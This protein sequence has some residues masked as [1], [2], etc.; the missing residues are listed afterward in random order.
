MRNRIFLALDLVLCAATVLLAFAARFEGVSWPPS[1]QSIAFAYLVVVV[2]L[3][4]ILLF[5]VGLYRR[6]WRYASIADLEIILIAAFLGALASFVVGFELPA[7]GLTA[8]RVPIGVMLLYSALTAAAISL[9]RLLLRVIARRA[10]SRR[11]R[12]PRGSLREPMDV[13][14][15]LIAGEFGYANP[16][17]DA[18]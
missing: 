3:K 9:P 15:V 11:T 18:V 8:G 13:R 7:A 4:I 12:G 2:P 1:I 10:R 5:S 16:D 6:V 17:E 14:R